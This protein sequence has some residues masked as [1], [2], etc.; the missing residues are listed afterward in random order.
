MKNIHYL[1][2]TALILVTKPVL[3]QENDIMK[4]LLISEEIQVK[5]TATQGKS[6]AGK[7]LDTAPQKIQIEGARTIRWRPKT[8]EEDLI[9]Y[10]EAPFG[11]NW[12]TS[13]QYVRN[14]NGVI[15]TD[16]STKENVLS[17]SANLLPKNIADFDNYILNF[18]YENKL[19][20]II[21]HSRPK[22]DDA[23]L[24]L[25]LNEYDKYA[26]LLSRKY[27][28]KTEF[29]SAKTSVVEEVK[30]QPN[31]KEEII[32][33][34]VKSEIGDQN[35][36]KD[37]QSGDVSLYSLFEGG[38]VGVALALNVDKDGKSYITIEYKSMK[39][40]KER[41]DKTLEAI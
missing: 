30:K 15:L 9:K 31:G 40:I 24:T 19:W 25:G 33:T 22:T 4:N 27:K 39:L 34:E 10:G 26:K 37:I 32:K 20:H 3:A 7:M 2:F 38:D 23:S 6:D 28:D 1:F 12:G 11:L 41:E 36:K 5:E 17:F 13:Q 18:G 8:Q 16:I 21:A 14:N 29:F 35:F